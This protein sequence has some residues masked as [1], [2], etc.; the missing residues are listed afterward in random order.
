MTILLT[1]DLD[2]SITVN[3]LL[4]LLYSDGL[5]EFVCKSEGHIKALQE[6]IAGGTER[7]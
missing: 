4:D 1:N 2:G 6:L 5:V 7:H 3:D